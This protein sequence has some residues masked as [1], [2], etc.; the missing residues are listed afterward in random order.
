MDGDIENLTIAEYRKLEK[1]FPEFGRFA[2]RLTA[3]SYDDFTNTL[4]QDIDE[5]ISQIQE[6]AE[7]RQ[8]DSE[9]RL[10]IDIRDQLNRLGYNASHESKHRGHADIIVEN[11]RKDFIWIGEAKIH[12]SYDYLWEGF[13]QLTT[14][15]S[16]GDCDQKE[17]GIF[18]YIKV[19]KAKSVIERWQKFLSEKNL[20]N[21][22][23]EPCKMR[24]LSFFSTH[25]HGV[26]G[27]NFKVRHMP[28]LLY[29]K[30]ED[31]SGRNKKK[32]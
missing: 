11:K 22:L 12:R 29:F 3:K 24:E 28:V 17:G 1:I 32:A 5:I 13:L 6:N 20:T 19:K 27:M 31:D 23:L 4:Y 9:D 8:K 21:Y 15:Y 16:T 30:P 25:E 14:R 7:Y 18:I 2:T 26:S 10:T